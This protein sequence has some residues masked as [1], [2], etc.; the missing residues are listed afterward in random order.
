MNHY[1]VTASW[2]SEGCYECEGSTGQAFVFV[3][4][5]DGKEALKLAETWLM[6]RPYGRPRFIAATKL[7]LPVAPQASKAKIIPEKEMH[8]RA[9]AYVS[10]LKSAKEA[11]DVGH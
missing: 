1:V 6:P 2:D 4:A 7:E 5:H 10:V 11:S 3:R 8:V 9:G